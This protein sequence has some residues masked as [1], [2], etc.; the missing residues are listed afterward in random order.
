MS[1]RH[2]AGYRFLPVW[3]AVAGTGLMATAWWLS[4]W[5]GPG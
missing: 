2:R 5:A 3:I 4:S 1:F